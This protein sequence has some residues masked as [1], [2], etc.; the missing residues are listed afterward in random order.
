MKFGNGLKWL[1]IR[2]NGEF[3]FVKKVINLHVP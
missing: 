2:F 3:F 1:R